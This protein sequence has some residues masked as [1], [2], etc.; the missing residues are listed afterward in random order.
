MTHL[1]EDVMSDAIPGSG[2][3]VAEE[4]PMEFS[5]QFYALFAQADTVSR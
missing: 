3:C 2:H 1:A 5:D 4:K